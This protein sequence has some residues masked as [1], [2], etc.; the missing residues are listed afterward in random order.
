MHTIT[1][2]SLS[3]IFLLF[4]ISSEELQAIREAMPALPWELYER[5]RKEFKLSDYDAQLLTEERSTARFYLDLLEKG[6]NKK[7]SCQP[8]YQ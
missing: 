3:P 7:G 1:V 5:F 6:T 8:D 2:T 4:L